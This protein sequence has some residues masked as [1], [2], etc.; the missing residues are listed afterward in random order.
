MRTHPLKSMASGPLKIKKRLFLY[1][2]ILKTGIPFEE[3]DS[4]LEL[5]RG[6]SFP[7]IELGVGIHSE[8]DFPFNALHC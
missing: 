8:L 2:Y 1:L 5:L 7:V 4:I 6:V 3:E